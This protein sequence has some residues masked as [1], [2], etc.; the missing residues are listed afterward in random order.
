[1][2]EAM[3]II[4]VEDDEGHAELAKMNLERS[5]MPQEVLHFS[6]GAKALDFLFQDAQAC[7]DCKYLV[8]LDIN[9]P[10]LDGHQVLKKLKG[11]PRTRNIPVIML[12]T[13]EDEREVER[14]YAMGCNLYINKPVDYQKF[15]EAITQFG[16]FIQRAKFPTLSHRVVA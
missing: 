16:Q 15:L 12:T 10:G 9:M 2:T 5:G 3:K 7:R 6:S 14:C 4:L 1:M 11:D 8:M 13:A